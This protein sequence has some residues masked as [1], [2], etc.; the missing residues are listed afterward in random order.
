MRNVAMHTQPPRRVA[1]EPR[2]GQFGPAFVA[3]SGTKVILAPA[4]RTVDRQ[5]SR[6]HGHKQPIG[7]LDDLQ[8]PNHKFIVERDAANR[9]EAITG[10]LN[11]LYAN[12]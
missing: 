9:F 3:K 4:L 12:I 6:R 7:P 11:Q 5:L 10:I 8:V 1:A 2:R